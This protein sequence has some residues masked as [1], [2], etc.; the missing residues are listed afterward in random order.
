[1]SYLFSMRDILIKVNIAQIN[2]I[3]RRIKAIPPLIL[4]INLIIK[5]VRNLKMKVLLL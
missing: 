3:N 2:A 1:M 4:E 5:Y